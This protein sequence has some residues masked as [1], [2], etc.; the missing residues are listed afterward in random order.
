MPPGRK[1]QP[2]VSRPRNHTIK[3][4]SPAKLF[5]KRCNSCS[6]C[7]LEDCGKCETCRRRPKDTSSQEM[8]ICLRKMCIRIPS[9]KKAQRAAGLEFGWHFIFCE[10]KGKQSVDSHD[11]LRLISPQGQTFK[12]VKEVLTNF[13]GCWEDWEGLQDTFYRQIGTLLIRVDDT[14]SL[15]G[16]RYCH[17]WTNVDGHTHSIC[18]TVTKCERNNMD[19]SFYQ[20]TV[21][22]DNKLRKLT[23]LSLPWALGGCIS[24]DQKFNNGTGKARLLHGIDSTIVPKYWSW[25]TPEARAEKLVLDKDGNLLPRLTMT[26]RGFQLTFNAMT[27]SIPQAGYG[28]F[29]KCVAFTQNAGAFVLAPGEILDIGVYAPF[30][31]ED[32]KHETVFLLKN[33]IHNLKCEEWSFDTTDSGFLFDITEDE[34]GNLHE[35][36]RSHIPAYVNE[37][38]PDSIASVKAEHDPD[39]NVHYL[40]GA[41][42][43]SSSFSLAADGSEHEIFI[44]YGPVYEH[45]RVRKGYS[46][47]PPDELSKQQQKDEDAEYISEILEMEKEEVFESLTFIRTL[48][49]N[50]TVYCSDQQVLRRTLTVTAML[51]HRGEIFSNISLNRL[52]DDILSTLLRL[53]MDVHLSDMRQSP[54]F[55]YEVVKDQLN[56]VMSESLQMILKGLKK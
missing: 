1:S 3:R 54:C 24:Y 41:A 4:Y 39:G 36:A 6:R 16:Q 20:F 19:D 27:S 22:F 56:G 45:V 2:P 40:L 34:T 35:L 31:K 11:G 28:V 32:R 33:Y 29:V 49:P 30:R 55:C 38:G 15:V 47:L 43:G 12:S 52:A 51:Q 53:R 5:Q 17:D 21:A 9:T 37:C 50:D 10:G 48:F 7:Q 23:R 18:G 13:G 42:D 25:I 44:N 46:R 8:E 26:V 14:H